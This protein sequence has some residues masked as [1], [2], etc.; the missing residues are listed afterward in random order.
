MPPPL[1]QQK[2]NIFNCIKDKIYYLKN[3]KQVINIYKEQKGQKIDPWGTPCKINLDEDEHL[4]KVTL[5]ESVCVN[6]TKY[7]PCDK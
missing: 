4:F 6:E 3:Q 7:L 1:Y 5:V 2:V